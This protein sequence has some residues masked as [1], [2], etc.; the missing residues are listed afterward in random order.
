MPQLVVDQTDSGRVPRS[1]RVLD[2]QANLIETQ[3]LRLNRALE[4]EGEMEGHLTPEVRANIE[5]TPAARDTKA[6][7]WRRARQ[8]PEPG[9]G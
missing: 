4:K 3:T 6:D 8:R 9:A 7:G 2:Q 5:L 1:I